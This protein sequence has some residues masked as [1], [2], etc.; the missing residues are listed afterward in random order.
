MKGRVFIKSS[1]EAREQICWHHKR[2]ENVPLSLSSTQQTAT[3]CFSFSLFSLLEYY[4]AGQFPPSHATNPFFICR[5]SSGKSTDIIHNTRSTVSQVET[6]S[7]LCI[8]K[9]DDVLSSQKLNFK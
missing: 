8:G 2:S 5:E 1:Q 4:R 6:I 9:V 7:V 3:S